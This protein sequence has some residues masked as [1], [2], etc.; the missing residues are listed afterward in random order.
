MPSRTISPRNKSIHFL[1]QTTASSGVIRNQSGT[2]KPANPLPTHRTEH[3]G[4][5]H[6]S[7]QHTP[8]T[9]YTGYMNIRCLIFL[10]SIYLSIST[11]FQSNFPPDH[12]AK[13]GAHDHKEKSK[14]YALARKQR[15]N[16]PIIIQITNLSRSL[17]R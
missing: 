15:S 7:S 8:T 12:Y 13:P 10:L 9:S 11:D 3:T 1:D 17:I 4:H 5:C 14:F 16:S 6:H 2:H